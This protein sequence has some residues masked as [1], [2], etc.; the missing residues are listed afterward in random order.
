VPLKYRHAPAE[1]KGYW[2]DNWTGPVE[3]TELD[4]TWMSPEATPVAVPKIIPIGVA[5]KFIP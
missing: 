3:V 1:T 4:W 2:K 5:L